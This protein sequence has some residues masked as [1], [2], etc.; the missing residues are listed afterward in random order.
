MPIALKDNLGR[1]IDNLRVSVTDRCNFRC[2][3]CMPEEGLQWVPEARVLQF[4]EIERLVRIFVGLGIRKVRLTGGEPLVRKGLHRLVRQLVAISGLE[5]LSL[6]TNGILLG[7]EAAALSEAGLRR[8]NVSLDSL[9]RE[10]FRRLARRDALE[11][12]L[13]SLEVARRH[14]PGPI[15]VNAVVLGG[16]N[17]TEIDGFVGL[18]RSGA[19][20]VRFIEFMPLDADQ[21]W[22]RGLL[23]TGAEILRRIEKLHPMAP[24]P[25]RDPHS[26]SRDYVFQDGAG[27]KIGF[28]NSVSE[29]FCHQC[30]RIRITAD[31]KL[32]T[33]LF[34]LGETDLLG[35]LREGAGDDDIAERARAAVRL[36]EPGHRINDADFVRS[37][38]TM[39]QIGG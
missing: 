31:G 5:D 28:I 1:T 2:V 18:A 10:T 13:E 16:M 27:G 17:D 26:P 39:S 11:Q 22:S 15:K 35:P 24:D 25:S 33:C 4:D 32:R 29:P 20:E 12:V 8:I 38:R 3:Y 21:I 23:V 6:T 9:T 34:S 14:F 36:K 19:F 37:G 30:N 7:Q